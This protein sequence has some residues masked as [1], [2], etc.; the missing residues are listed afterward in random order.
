MEY[1]PLGAIPT[2]SVDAAVKEITAIP[3]VAC[4]V[5]RTENLKRSARHAF[6][7]ALVFAVPTVILGVILLVIALFLSGSVQTLFGVLPKAILGV[8]QSHIAAGED[9]PWVNSMLSTIPEDARQRWIV[10]NV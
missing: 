7:L 1:F 6:I 9:I 3:I 2:H 8:I 10:V 5:L 4:L